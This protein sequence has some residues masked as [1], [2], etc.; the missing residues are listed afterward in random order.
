MKITND[1]T[2]P[3]YLRGNTA[4]IAERFCLRLF[5]TQQFAKCG[6]ICSNLSKSKTTQGV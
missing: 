6:K 5:Y 3:K 4:H 2:C 1:G